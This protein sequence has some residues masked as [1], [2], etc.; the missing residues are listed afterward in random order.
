MRRGGCSAGSAAPSAIRRPMHDGQKPRPLVSNREE[1]RLSLPGGAAMKT[2]RLAG[3]TEDEATRLL[4]GVSEDADSN[5]EERRAI[6]SLAERAYR[7][8]MGLVSLA[9]YARRG[10]RT[11]RFREILRDNALLAAFHEGG[12]QDVEVGA[13]GRLRPAPDPRLR[14]GRARAPASAGLPRAAQ[15]GRPR[16]AGVRE[17]PGRP[18]RL[19]AEPSR[20]RFLA[21]GRAVPG[22]S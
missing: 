17:G 19:I 15:G 14:R 5:P 22:S 1:P 2:I 20:S 6:V 7:I 9:Q 16:P 10:A 8:P 3:M 4:K 21:G 11:L 18:R 12:S 13:P